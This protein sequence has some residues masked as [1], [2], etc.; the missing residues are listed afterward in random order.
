MMTLRSGF[1]RPFR[2]R[3]HL[4]VL[5]VVSGLACAESQSRVPT[6]VVFHSVRDGNAEIYVMNVDGTGAIGLT[7]HSAQDT[8]PDI[9]PD[10]RHIV[11]TSD[12]DGNGDLF[13][14]DVAGG[15]A[16]NLTRHAAD[17]GWGR[18]S[19]DGSRIA[20]HS[21]RDGNYEIY[22]MNADG[23]G[24]TRITEHGG[25]DVFPEWTP[26]GSRLIF[27]RDHDLWMMMLDGTDARQLTDAPTNDQM[28]VVSAD[29]QR[30]AFATRRDGYFALYV[31]NADG[32][33]QR[34]LTP[35]AEG[36]EADK[37]LNG[38]PAWSRDGRI[39]FSSARSTTAH[40]A[41]IFVV[42]AD[43]TGLTRLTTAPGMD[44]SA[45]PF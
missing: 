13:T 11:F 26:D 40:D 45:R 36:D 25:E 20:F 6:R 24:V 34:N 44:V 14:M 38:W 18:W 22:V 4:L 37:L 3:A 9:S 29:G 10:G 12:R 28:A 17:D 5:A 8:D 16:T 1:A 27:R 30:I 7:L 15:D 41:E 23:S 19:P 35:I 31:M 2:A 32:T 39:F 42:N 43:G 33:E 21:D